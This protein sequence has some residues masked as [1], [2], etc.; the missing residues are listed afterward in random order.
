MESL[1]HD[2]GAE[3][4]PEKRAPKDEEE[5]HLAILSRYDTIPSNKFLSPLFF[6]LGRPLLFGGS[7]NQGDCCYSERSMEPLRMVIVDSREW[8]V[9]QDDTIIEV[10]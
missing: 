7:S 10:A 8:E 2:S 6:V 4:E 5:D 1:P 3:E 9:V